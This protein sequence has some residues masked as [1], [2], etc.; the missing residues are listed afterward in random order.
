MLVSQRGKIWMIHVSVW[1]TNN[2]FTVQ[3]IDKYV[4]WFFVSHVDQT[5]LSLLMCLF[6]VSTRS[7]FRPLP[8]PKKIHPELDPATDL[9]S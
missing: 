7:A 3:E 6:L 1:K 4:T 8:V 9:P 5:H 2:R